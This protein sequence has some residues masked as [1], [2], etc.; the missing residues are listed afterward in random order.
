MKRTQ[1]KD[2]LRNIWKQKVS[3]LSIVVIAM[4]GVTMFLGIDFTAS[5]IWKNA[6][7]FY[8]EKNYRDIELTS[9]LLLSED[10]ISAIRGTEGVK[11]VEG[12]YFTSA[13]ASAN[14]MRTNAEVVSL[15]ERINLPILYEGRLPES[16]AECAVEKNIADAL[17]I[18]VG[19]RISVTDAK[20][21][22]AQYMAESE[23][24]VCG[25][26][27]HP[28]HVCTSIPSTPYIIVTADAFDTAIL[29]GCFMKAE[30]VTDRPG[31]SQFDS[32]YMSAVGKVLE[33]IEEHGV[34]RGPLRE[35]EAC[36]Q[37][38]ELIAEYTAQLNAAE[39]E[40]SDARAQ[41][42]QG[43]IDLENGE[44][45]YAEGEQKLSAVRAE[46]DDAKQQLNDGLEKL[47]ATRA[48]LNDARTELDAGKAE[49]DE[50]KAVLD[51]ARR[52]LVSGW[53]QL[54]DTK[55]EIR[56][57]LRQE[58]ELVCGAEAAG[59]IH[60]AGRQ[61]A[62]PDSRSATASEFRITENI[63]IDL[64]P[65]KSLEEFVEEFAR[66]DRIPDEVLRKVFFSAYP[67]DEYDPETARDLLTV[68]LV[69][70]SAAYEN[71]YME[72]SE[73]CDRWDR[74][75]RSY[76]SGKKQ[77]E[78]GL[79]KYEA[80]LAKYEDGEAQYK[81]GLQQYEEALAAYNEGEA[82]YEQGVIELN[83]A[84]LELDEAK[85]KLEEGEVK[86]AD[87][88]KKLD[89]GKLSL[90]EAEN[91]FSSLGPCK[92]IILDASGNASYIQLR[93]SSVNLRSMERT[94]ALMFVLVGA[95]V[96]YATISKI[97]DEQR[98][99]VGTTKALGFFNR[100]IFAKYL[101]FGVSA[102]VLG[103]AVGLINALTW[104]Q[105]FLLNS[106]NIYFAIDIQRRVLVLLPTLIAFAAGI[107]LAFAAIWFATRKLMKESAIRLMQPAVPKG[108]VK[109]RSVKKLF[110]SLYSRLILKNIRSDLRRVIV[111][112]V[113]VAGCCALVVIGIMLKQAVMG[114]ETK[115]F[116]D[117][118]G[119]DGKV[120]FEPEAD[121]AAA[122]AIGTRLDEAGTEY[123]S[124]SYTYVTSR[125]DRLQVYEMFCGDLDEIKEHY[126][127]RDAGTGALIGSSDDGIL[128][129]KRL[130]EI[131]G[132]R[133][134]DTIEIALNGTEA[135]SVRVVGVF[136]CYMDRYFFMS[137]ACYNSLFGRDPVPNVFFV[138]LCG[139]DADAMCESLRS[140]AGFES[141]E[142]VSK[143]K[144]LFESA[145]SA[146]NA[147]M[148]L[149]IAMAGIMA[150]VVLM[151]LTNIYIMQ[152]KR[153]LTI[154]RINGF[155]VKETIGY[156]LRETFVTTAVGIF[157]GIG[158][159]AVI[160]YS[161]IRSLE[162]GAVQFD[163]SPKPLAWLIGALI[164]IAFTVIVNAIALRKVR[165]LKLTDV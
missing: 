131:Y 40:L 158:L 95:L 33:L 104:A 141:Y 22:A 15:T 65:S 55:S 143:Q 101:S 114:A 146:L 28:D 58:I 48:Q 24:T 50:A 154:M 41:L 152:K 60:W 8:N 130:S 32:A 67:E 71:D 42:D 14:G 92:W 47:N 16:K 102:A 39:L 163:R 61:N 106:Y 18:K 38:Q 145:T 57:M 96:I 5:A 117:V 121:P 132:I 133:P 111:T 4:L 68:S 140:A 88:L 80:A 62:N 129:P 112:V 123:A 56:D 44:E 63:K 156:V 99:L 45:Q 64:D 34:T 125:T 27:V 66:S 124:A 147:L 107:V 103:V 79:A 10:D 2:A 54:E 1:L 151:N 109:T 89:E 69:A 138:K 26:I 91:R 7:A 127:L 165:H 59:K 11:D 87:G 122:E 134:G 51:S 86:Y 157:I 85:Q 72:L 139:A 142:S 49:L 100:E 98:T 115:Q 30:I 137:S 13:K 119:F 136:N 73:A 108:A 94:F 155:T 19:G 150:G 118:I 161:I 126:V 20:G 77:Y 110:L 43:Y 21:G 9:T 52:Q 29:G 116:R 12:V 83:D 162:Q 46:L 6:S 97:V 17:D 153:E 90:G 120:W 3:F 149:F 128:I 164:T 70:A 74:G 82:Q 25:I 75:H 113:S 105:A 31:S 76:L 93:D 81:E 35:E 23:F 135:A 36:A 144:A 53:N 37:V 160:G 148:M 84:R 159:G 78:E